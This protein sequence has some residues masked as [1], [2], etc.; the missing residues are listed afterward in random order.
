MTISSVSVQTVDVPVA[1]V[2]TQEV[3]K[4]VPVLA[5]TRR[6]ACAHSR[7]Q[8]AERVVENVQFL[9]VRR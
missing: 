3:F 6:C 4:Q 5:M 7:G 8:T 9:C 1:Q 2:M